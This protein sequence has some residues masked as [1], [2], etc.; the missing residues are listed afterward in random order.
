M[1][2][3]VQHTVQLF[4]VSSTIYLKMAAASLSL[5]LSLF[6]QEELPDG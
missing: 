6:L 1:N 3:Y 2:N 4:I 5:S